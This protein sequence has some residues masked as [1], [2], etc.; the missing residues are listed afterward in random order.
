MH[1]RL[2]IF[3]A[4]LAVLAVAPALAAP[5]HAAT[6]AAAKPAGPTPKELGRFDE[7]TAA[8]YE[9]AGQTICYAFTRAKPA[10]PSSGAALPLLTVT[11]RANN[12]DEVAITSPTAYAKDASVLLQVGQAG[13]DFY[14]SG[15]DAFARDG[16]AAVAAMRRGDEAITRGHNTD[17]YSLKGFTQA[18]DAIVKACPAH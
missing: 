17:T 18:Y 7:W 1:A 10:G 6:S 9:N 8:T 16:K 12:R 3:A 15:R 5:K 2:P 4:A 11:E 13:L 14:T